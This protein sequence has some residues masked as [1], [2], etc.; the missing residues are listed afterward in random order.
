MAL[1]G[2]QQL[3]LGGREPGPLGRVF[4]EAQEYPEG[5]TEPGQRLVLGQRQG[6]RIRHRWSSPGCDAPSVL[7]RHGS[8]PPSRDR[9]EWMR[10]TSLVTSRATTEAI[11]TGGTSR[12]PAISATTSTEPSG[13]LVTPQQA[14]AI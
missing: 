2:Q 10:P 3:V 7:P 12:S 6:S 8:E 1:H 4:R 5:V 9:C 11:M 14:A 13:V